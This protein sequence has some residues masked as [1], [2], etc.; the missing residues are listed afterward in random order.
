MVPD[1]AMAKEYGADM[2]TYSMCNIAPQTSALNE[3]KWVY[4]E[5]MIS[6]VG[7][8]RKL[9]VLAGPLPPFGDDPA[10]CLKGGGDFNEQLQDDP[11]GCS[12]SHPEP[13]PVS[14]PFVPRGMWKIV[15]DMEQQLTFVFLFNNDFMGPVCDFNFAGEK[16]LH[17]IEAATGYKFPPVWRNGFATSKE[18]FVANLTDS[19]SVPSVHEDQC[20]GRTAPT[21]C[22]VCHMPPPAQIEA[23][24][25]I[26]LVMGVVLL[27]ALATWLFWRRQ[28]QWNSF[29]DN[30][31]L[32]NRIDNAS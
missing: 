1:S 26:V 24:L 15:R 11:T 22:V 2:Q 18:Q 10:Q 21:F 12:G 7:L 16:G 3:R 25:V 32:G 27:G 19:C 30:V 13:W 20:A 28:R 23:L 29:D 14:R 31:E 5:K 6:C 9:V 8:Q 17:D 4:F